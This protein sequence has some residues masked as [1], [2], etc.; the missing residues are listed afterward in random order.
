MH[1]VNGLLSV[2]FFLSGFCS[3]LYQI[4]WMR[5]AF[6]SY[7][8]VTP[9]MS[10]VISVFM[11][12]LALGSWAGGKWARAL[13]VKT[14]LPPA[15][16]YAVA[17]AIIGIGGLAVPALF[18]WGQQL[19]LPVG[20]ID[21]V[22]YLVASGAAIALSLLP[23][24]VCMGATFP[25]MMS[26]GG[27]FSFLYRA[28]VI[29]ALV[30]VLTSAWVLI[31]LLGL[32]GTLWVAVA[33]NFVIAAMAWRWGGTAAGAE[34]AP[35]AHQTG[36]ASVGNAVVV[37][38]RLAMTVLFLT[39]FI[40][41]SLEVIWTRDFTPVLRT[42]V[43]SFAQLL[44]VY[45]LA[46][47]VGAHF[48]RRDVARDRVRALS[49]ILGFLALFSFLPAFANDPRVGGGAWGVF[50]GIFP[51]CAALGYLTPKIIDEISGG[52]A[53]IAGR[54]YAA[55]V[56]GCI[57]GPLLATYLFLPYCGVRIS[58]V[59]HAVPFMALYLWSSGGLPL[60]RRASVC[61]M[62]LVLTAVSLVAVE[63][64]EEPISHLGK[65]AQIRR[66]HTAT[67]ISAGTGMGK[68]LLVN[69]I[70][71]TH[72]TPVTKTMAH[73]PLA[74]LGRPSESALVICFGM[75][76]TFRSLLSW[77]INATAVELVPSVRDAFPFYFSDAAEV[78]ANPRGKIVV[79]DGRRF[80]ERTTQQ[81]DLI[82]LDPPPPVE[83]AASSLLYSEE[84]YS[85]VSAHLKPDGVLQQWF[86]FGEEPILKAIAR[87]L[88]NSFP[89]LRVF[90]SV[91]GWGYHFIASKSPIKEAVAADMAARLPQAA[92]KDLLQWNPGDTARGMFQRMIA[93]ETTA[94]AIIAG[95]PGR[96]ITDDRPYNEYY[97]LRR[98]AQSL[99]GRMD[100]VKRKF[101]GATA[102][103]G[104]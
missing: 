92:V 8:V 39:G 20:D 30:G 40:S 29:G 45:L 72:L 9:V 79:D 75:G 94:D 59:A 87:S 23:W 49:G 62:G 18:L 84:F 11:L 76:T 67:I 21:S 104:L 22:P 25:L 4:V 74:L 35:A 98:A 91:D 80:L 64:F 69:G 28:N 13:S 5:L 103:Q 97:Y 47:A 33:V 56:L 3:L 54:A 60:W 82:T 51:F 77:G 17:E 38:R 90:S 93:H 99:K 61:V 68:S 6:A 34:S 32:R 102:E 14:K 37:R 65:E 19:L 1:Q 100:R 57:M 53:A 89:Y 24:C 73:F 58:M 88:K 7:G 78:L 27:E 42:T 12:G 44:F 15:R 63:S 71:I 10:V 55:N 36:A 43:Y 81:F 26:R 95:E 96:A 83:A 41:M 48:Y 50:F 2:L 70:G 85:L 52:D 101:F 86:P 46:T 16:L 66:D 31:E